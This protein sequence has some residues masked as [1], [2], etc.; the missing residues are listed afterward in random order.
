VEQQG[1]QVAIGAVKHLP[2][3]EPVITRHLMGSD[4]STSGGSSDS[5]LKELTV[6]PTKRPSASQQV[7]RV[8]PVA[9]RPSACRSV[10]VSMF[11]LPDSGGVQGGVRRCR[12]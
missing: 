2:D 8:T 12:R 10:R 5:E 6:R 4:H 11:D 1:R 7:T 9:N 3:E